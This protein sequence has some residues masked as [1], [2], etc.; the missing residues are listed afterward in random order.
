MNIRKPSDYSSLYSALD[1]LMGSDLAE[2]E[3][4]CEI[5]RAV[6]GR[7]EKGAAVM[8]AEYLQSRYP[9]RK[10]F[11]P[12]NLRRMRLFYLT[13]GN[14]PD[15]LEKALKLAWTQN[16]TILDPAKQRRNGRGISMPHWSMA[17]IRQNCSDRSRMARGGFIGS[18]NRR[19]SA[20]LKK[21]KL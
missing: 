8:A 19:I 13:Y 7:T 4:Y 2:M 15:R 21:K 3:L 5:G 17:G 20:I 9:E 14:T 18:T 6:C 11:S 1:V 12:R 10:G 16:V